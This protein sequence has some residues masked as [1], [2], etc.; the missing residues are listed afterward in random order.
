MIC[1]KRS[2][3]KEDW[4][5]HLDSYRILAMA[6]VDTADA[7]VPSSLLQSLRWI[8]YS[9]DLND[10]A[11][12]TQEAEELETLQQLRE[13]LEVFRAAGR[14]S[15]KRYDA[16]LEYEHTKLQGLQQ[17]YHQLW[18]QHGRRTSIS[19]YLT[20]LR[21]SISHIDTSAEK[22][23]QQHSHIPYVQ[24]WESQVC[25]VYHRLEIL[26][27]QRNLMNCQAKR[28]VECMTRIVEELREESL[29]L[30]HR[31]EIRA[32][33]IHH[34]HSAM[35]SNR[36]AILERQNTIRLEL[37]AHDTNEPEEEEPQSLLPVGRTWIGMFR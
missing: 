32:R 4:R 14:E 27:R 1:L 29:C 35:I 12:G 22:G 37:Y 17:K 10:S 30:H 21:S 36:Q 19:P 33:E 25:Q 8:S 31:L 23:S 13:E 34:E 11:L 15:Q 28:E 9:S 2:S 6:N 16:A 18:N 20:T 3:Q 24:N 26:K 5:H 7:K